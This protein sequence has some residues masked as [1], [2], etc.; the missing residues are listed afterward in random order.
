MVEQARQAR[1]GELGTRDQVGSDKRA[2]YGG[3]GHDDQQRP[4]RPPAAR[5]IAGTGG[6]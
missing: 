4:R 2:A 6:T 3:A 5:A 1:V